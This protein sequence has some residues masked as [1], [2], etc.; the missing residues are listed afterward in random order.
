MID[1]MLKSFSLH[2]MRRLIVL[3]FV[4][5]LVGAGCLPV[6]KQAREDASIGVA[7][8]PKVAVAESAGDATY[9]V[10][11]RI[12]KL[13]KGKAEIFESAEAKT[14]TPITLSDEHGLGDLNADGT[15]DEAYFLTRGPDAE[16][17]RWTFAVAAIN[18][19]GQFAGTTAFALGESITPEK[20]AI[21]GDE[22]VA[23]YKAAGT[24]SAEITK[25]F[26]VQQWKVVESE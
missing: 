6:K 7:T 18:I 4:L 2:R 5:V 13:A 26:K 25:R 24:G 11:R 9:V 16:G 19:D 8:R 14:A 1:W 21:E 22:I 10:D 12:I 17:R 3:S 23:T 20:I 15:A